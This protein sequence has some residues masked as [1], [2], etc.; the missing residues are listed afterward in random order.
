MIERI[1]SKA[2]GRAILAMVRERD[3]L[4]RQ[5]NEQIAEINAALE[6]QADVL[7]LAFGLPE[8]Q[9]RF[10]GDTREVKLVGEAEAVLAAQRAAA[11]AEVAAEDADSADDA[12]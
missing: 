9:Y 3:D 11:H 12:G 8:G 1:L 2:Q 7:R 6:A 10:E 4:T 5:A